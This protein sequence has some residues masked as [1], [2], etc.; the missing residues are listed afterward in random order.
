MAKTNFV[1]EDI[2]I[3]PTKG[4]SSTNEDIPPSLADSYLSWLNHG[5]APP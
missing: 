2:P 3:P 5:A 4:V 1:K